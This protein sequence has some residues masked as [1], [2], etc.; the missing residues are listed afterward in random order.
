MSG[1]AFLKRW[2]RLKLAEGEAHAGG[3]VAHPSSVEA[4]PS[5]ALT[6]EDVVRLGPD[7]DYAAFMAAGVSRA[8]QRLA[9]K[10]LFADPHFN[11]MDRLDVYI[12]DYNRA[13]PV[14]AAMLASLQHTADLLARGAE[15]EA[16]LEAA[17]DMPAPD[18]TST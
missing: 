5:P 17:L 10:K 14:S 6:L 4:Q 18:E 13:S 12:D 11:V 2:S 7:A 1:E 9:M 3:V 15:L 16:R 8:V